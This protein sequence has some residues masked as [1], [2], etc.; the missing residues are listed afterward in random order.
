MYYF[1]ISETLSQI[2]NTDIKEIENTRRNENSIEE[3]IQEMLLMKNTEGTL[4]FLHKLKKNYVIC[5]ILL[6]IIYC[7]KHKNLDKNGC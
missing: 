1:N 5:I 6:Y 7:S 4:I 2:S 3:S